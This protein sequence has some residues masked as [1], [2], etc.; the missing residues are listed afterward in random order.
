MIY[1]SRPD[2]TKLERKFVNDVLKTPFLSLG[3]KLEEFENNFSNYIGSKHSVAVNS[4]TSGLHLAL[5]ALGISKGDEVITTPF[6]FIASANCILFVGAKPVFVDIDP[7]TLNID[8]SRIEQAITSRTKAILAVD[9]FGYPAEWYRLKKIAK[10]YNLLLIEDACEAIGAEYNGKKTGNFGD[11]GVFGFYPNKQITTGEGGIISTN[12]KTFAEICKSLRNQGRDSNTR[13]LKHKRI[14]YNYRISELN[15]ALGLAQLQRID[16]ILDKRENVANY[17]I[18]RLSD[19]QNIT[20][21]QIKFINNKIRKSW[22][23]FPI[24]LKA[25]KQKNRDYVIRE[26][27]KRKIQHGVYFPPIHLQKIYRQLF[28]YKSGSFPL[29]EKISKHILALPF[30]TGLK[31]KDVDYVCKNLIK[32]L[33]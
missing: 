31:K 14:G 10:K 12:S 27:L 29:T 15:C 8:A 1:L 4:G 6:S 16:D 22:F 21:P 7:E 30:Y 11:C 32:I 17:Y 2:I 23:V 33:K 13:W 26:L 3:P 9:V 28:N 5:L 20:I 18:D 25:K 24:L 19:I